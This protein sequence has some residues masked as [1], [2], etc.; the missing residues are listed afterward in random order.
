MVQVKYLASKL[1]QSRL[2]ASR[3]RAQTQESLAPTFV[4]LEE[5]SNYYNYF[6]KSHYF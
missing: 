5:F 1:E 4:L 2:V 6:L 3:V